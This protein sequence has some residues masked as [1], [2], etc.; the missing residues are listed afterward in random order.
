MMMHVCHISWVFR[1]KYSSFPPIGVYNTQSA[2]SLAPLNITWHLL[3]HAH[4]GW[5]AGCSGGVVQTSQ[6]RDF[7]RPMQPS[8]QW[9]SPTS[10]D[11]P[12]ATP[13]QKRKSLTFILLLHAPWRTLLRDSWFHARKKSEKAEDRNQA[14]LCLFQSY[15]KIPVVSF[16][17]WSMH[18]V[19]WSY[20][21]QGE[22]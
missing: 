15:E 21:S 2:E 1:Q 8:A 11:C 5:N 22:W 13:V 16:V 14:H 20:H 10:L 7:L 17:M 6:D 18:L 12:P 4:A 19:S 3:R 9:T